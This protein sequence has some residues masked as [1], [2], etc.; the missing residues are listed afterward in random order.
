M[1]RDGVTI[2]ILLS[3]YLIIG[4]KALETLIRLDGI[5]VIDFEKLN[6]EN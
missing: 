3:L 2:M 5:P 1:I 4:K 6:I